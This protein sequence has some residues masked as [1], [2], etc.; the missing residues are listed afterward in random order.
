MLIRYRIIY[1]MLIT[2]QCLV[3]GI[4]TV[5]IGTCTPDCRRTVRMLLFNS[6]HRR[7]MKDSDF[8][9]VC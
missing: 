5:G 2:H 8:L 4:G 7:T 6:I 3:V 9:G 1:E